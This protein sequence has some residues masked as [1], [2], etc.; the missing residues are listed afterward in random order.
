MPQKARQSLH[1]E[2]SEIK[3]SVKERLVSIY[4]AMLAIET[5]APGLLATA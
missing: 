1:Y 2:M 4:N 5:E 3:S